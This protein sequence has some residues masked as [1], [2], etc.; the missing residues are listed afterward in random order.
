MAARCILPLAAAALLAGG[1]STMEQKPLGTFERS[2]ELMAAVISPARPAGELAQDDG[3]QPFD[4]LDFAGVARGQTIAQIATYDPYFT[5]LL[6]L[7]VGPE[8]KVY[9][10]VPQGLSDVAGPIRD[11]AAQFDTV[12]VLDMADFANLQMPEPI[13]LVWAGLEYHQLNG[14]HV[15]AHNRAIH[16]ALK[17][18]G[19]Y[20]VEQATGRGGAAQGANPATEGMRAYLPREDVR[21]AGFT[22]EAERERFAYPV[23]ADA[24]PDRFP[25]IVS[26]RFRK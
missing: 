18:G 12:E 24:D 26:L 25:E 11:V 15:D 9:A 1:C 19:I 2:E 20:F 21:A 7:A 14:E 17:P 6:A 22:L 10:L 5:R 4:R 13:D 8:G 16:A 23:P 3:R